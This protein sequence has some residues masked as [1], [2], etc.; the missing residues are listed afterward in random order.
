MGSHT[1]TGV[2]L[3]ALALGLWAA[4]KS[5]RKAAPALRIAYYITGHGLG[6]A[7][8]SSAVS[9]HCG[10]SLFMQ[11]LTCYFAF[12]QLAKALIKRGHHVILVSAGEAMFVVFKP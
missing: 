5:A 3:F 12:M 11:D 7:V 4:K 10:G 6:H 2:A 9:F 8:R 1:A